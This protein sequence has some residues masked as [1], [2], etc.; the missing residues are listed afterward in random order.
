VEISSQGAFGVAILPDE[1]LEC[2]G[3][4]AKRKILEE[5]FQCSNQGE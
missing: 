2:D 1:G 5:R 3:I 4:K